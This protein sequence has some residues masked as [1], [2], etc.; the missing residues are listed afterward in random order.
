MKKFVLFLSSIVLITACS[1]SAKKKFGI[2]ENL[3]DEFQ[4]SKGKDLEIPP[5]FKL[6]NPEAA[7]KSKKPHKLTKSEEALLK[8]IK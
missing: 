3:P 1:N 2:S 6:A 4:V 5:H 8:E 7:E